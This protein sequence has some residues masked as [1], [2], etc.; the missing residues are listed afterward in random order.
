MA[1]IVLPSADPT[2]RHLA[3]ITTRYPGQECEMGDETPCDGAPRW[4]LTAPGS[5][6][7]PMLC[8]DVHAELEHFYYGTPVPE[9][10]SPRRAGLVVVH[11]QTCA[12]PMCER[13]VR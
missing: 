8:C 5:Y 10:T 13:D 6:S 1:R 9:T 11:D 12:C 3:R 2:F 4:W 7:V